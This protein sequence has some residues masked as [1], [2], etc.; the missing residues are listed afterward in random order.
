MQPTMNT[1]YPTSRIPVP[2]SGTVRTHLDLLVAAAQSVYDL[3]DQDGQGFDE[4]FANGGICDAVA[5]GMVAALTEMGVENALTFNAAVGENHTF[6]I[7][8]LEDGVYEIDIPP[9]VYE[10]GSGYTWKK[11]PGITIQ[12]NDVAIQKLSEAVTAVE[13]LE[14]YSE[15]F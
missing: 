4:Q 11:R 14:R 1:L 9:S 15:G 10:F 2:D 6:V 8:L 7:A 13:F 5:D 3:W 12:A